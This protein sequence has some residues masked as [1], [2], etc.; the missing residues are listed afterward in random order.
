M[1]WDLHSLANP[2]PPGNLKPGYFYSATG[3]PRPRVHFTS[4]ILALVSGDQTLKLQAVLFREAASSHVLLF[5]MSALISQDL[6]KIINSDFHTL[7]IF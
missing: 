7:A 4:P 1:C 3:K 5:L 6:Y 2:P